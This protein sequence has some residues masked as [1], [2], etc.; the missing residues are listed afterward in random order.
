MSSYLYLYSKPAIDDRVI[1]FWL[2]EL[3][4]RHFRC[5]LHPEFSF[6]QQ[7]GYLSL[8]VRMVGGQL[9]N[10]DGKDYM[11]GFE[12]DVKPYDHETEMTEAANFARELRVSG[13]PLWKR[14]LHLSWQDD[15]APKPPRRLGIKLRKTRWEMTVRSGMD[16]PLEN[17]VIWELMVVLAAVVDGVLF[18]PE[19][20][21][22]YDGPLAAERAQKLFIKLR[23][24]LDEHSRLIPFEEWG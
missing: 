7:A 6:E 4:R 21:K 19:Q 13:F 24:T 1:P 23:T 5:E 17:A 14:L 12:L 11:I 2:G 18:D 20:K 10:L 15:L 8:K 22:Y 16:N 3:A 9:P